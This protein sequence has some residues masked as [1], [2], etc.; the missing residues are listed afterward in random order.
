M[1]C[2]I[3]GKLMASFTHLRTPDGEIKTACPSCVGKYEVY[4]DMEYERQREEGLV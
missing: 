3:C 4:A 1:E 2:D